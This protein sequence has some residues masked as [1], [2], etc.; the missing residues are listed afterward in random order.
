MLIIK[1]IS[2]LDYT[3]CSISRDKNSAKLAQLLHFSQ[4]WPI[5]A[6]SSSVKFGKALKGPVRD[7]TNYFDPKSEFE[8]LTLHNYFG[9]FYFFCWL[10]SRLLNFAWLCTFASHFFTFFLIFCQNPFLIN[11]LKSFVVE[12]ILVQFESI[13]IWQFLGLFWKQFLS[14]F[15]SSSFVKLWIIFW[16]IWDHF[17]P[18]LDVIWNIFAYLSGIFI[19]SLS[20]FGPYLVQNAYFLTSETPGS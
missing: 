16:P 17:A 1:A 6:R 2:S 5:F 3:N 10:I 14:H 4:N 20:F 7:P 8:K 18:F 9:I 11:F 15:L 13:S 12:C 19:H